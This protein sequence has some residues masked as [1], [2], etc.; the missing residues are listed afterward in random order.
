LARRDQVEKE[1]RHWLLATEKPT[2]AERAKSPDE[3]RNQVSA[4]SVG[5]RPPAGETAEV[6]ARRSNIRATLG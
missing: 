4:V 5:E 6:L 1:S 3:D 2:V